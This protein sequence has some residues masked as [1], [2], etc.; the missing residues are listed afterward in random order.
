MPI[1]L[2]EDNARLTSSL[3]RGCS[4]CDLMVEA[5]DTGTAALDRLKEQHCDAVILDLGLPD[6]DGVDVLVSARS[7]GVNV[8]VLVL[9]ARDAVEQRV[10]ALDCGADDYLLKPFVFAELVARVRALVR[11]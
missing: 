4:E 5:V 6:I 1:L 3:V 7:M 8:P 11:R 2:V 9:S 10:E